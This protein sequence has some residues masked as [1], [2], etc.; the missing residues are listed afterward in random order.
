VLIGASGA[1]FLLRF[2]GGSRFNYFFCFLY[3]SWDSLSLLLSNE[4]ITE[5]TLINGGCDP[6]LESEKADRARESRCDGTFIASGCDPKLESENA[7]LFS[8]AYTTG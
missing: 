1:Y 6:R 3:S 4:L 8:G 2:K 5:G 7:D